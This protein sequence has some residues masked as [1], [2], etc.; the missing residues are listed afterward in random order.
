M[1]HTNIKLLY[2]LILTLLTGSLSAA[3]MKKV[4]ILDFADEQNKQ[5][6]KFLVTSITKAVKKG[7]KERFVFRETSRQEWIHTAEDNF[8]YSE[9]Y[10][11]KSAAM[12]L[13]VRS[14][15]DI[16][17]AG[18]FHIESPKGAGR[19]SILH[20]RVRILDIPEQK[21][22]ADFKMVNKADNTIFASIEKI[23]ARITSEART[24]L[25]SKEEWARGGQA[26]SGP[27][28]L[29]EPV[30]GLRA[31]GSL[32][33][34]GY[35]DR[36]ELRQP[37]LGMLLRSKVPAVWSQL[38]LGLDASFVSHSWKK[39]YN[40]VTR[41]STIETSNYIIG[42]R[43]GVEVPLGRKLTL[44]PFAGGGLVLQ[45]TS[46]TGEVQQNTSN[47]FPYFGGGLEASWRISRLFELTL[48][49]VNVTEVEQGTVT[50]L[51]SVQAGI[52]FRL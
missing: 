5:D 23:A 17:I 21:V 31:G 32:Y 30:L 18:S 15:Q 24:V 11:T 33:S 50:L 13:G 49:L 52:N 39:D 3:A 7:L 38:S 16:V 48:G 28:L 41:Q 34:A 8:L 43:L 20:T 22:V 6:N 27:P 12:N 40:Q 47:S 29:A 37:T 1:M 44:L 9:D 4:I 10:H 25:P 19:T 46:I 36:L 26:E 42:S 35:A 45:T 2:C 14:N 51:N